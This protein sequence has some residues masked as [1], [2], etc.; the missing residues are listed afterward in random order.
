MITLRTWLDA[1]ARWH[2]A[3]PAAAPMAT[4][5]LW[6]PA[7]LPAAEVARPAAALPDV[8]VRRDGARGRLAFTARPAGLDALVLALAGALD[9]E[10]AR[11]VRARVDAAGAWDGRPAEGS[12]AALATHARGRWVDAFIDEHRVWPAF[13]PIVDA[14][15]PARVVG[16]EALLR[17]RT[18]A[19]EAVGPLELLAHARA[20]DR[21]PR[22]DLHARLLALAAHRTAGLPGQIFLNFSPPAACASPRHLEPTLELLDALGLARDRVVLEI[23][24]TDRAADLAAFR[25]VVDGYRAAG[26]AIALDDVG[27]GYST[28]GLLD[29]LRPDYVKIDMGLVRG[30]HADPFRGAITAKLLELARGL[31]VRTIAEGVEELAEWTWLREHG[32]DLVQGHLFGRPASAAERARPD[33][34]TVVT[35][36]PDSQVA[37][38]VPAA[39]ATVPATSA[40]AAAFFRPDPTAGPAVAAEGT[41]F[42]AEA[43]VHPSRLP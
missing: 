22:L 5:R 8:A 9:A 4:L 43:P 7:D 28:L 33:A 24:E 26:L 2:G 10:A 34:T 6:L 13:Q 36:A 12:L 3:H 35:M 19:G 21:L 25:R 15:M 20:T 30:V 38:G 39:S 17:A 11:E 18:A 41:A 37:T 23:T 31:G 32:A 1:A 14:A 42:L 16:H 29:Q 27:S 40:A